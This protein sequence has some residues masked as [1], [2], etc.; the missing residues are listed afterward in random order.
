[1]KTFVS[2]FAQKREYVVTIGVF[3]GIHKGHQYLLEKLTESSRACDA[4]SLLI[5]FWPHPE[6]VL[7]KKAFG[8]CITTLSQKEQLLRR[9]APDY[10]FVLPTNKRL[11]TL[12]GEDFLKRILRVVRIKKIVVGDDFRFGYMAKNTVRDLR[13]FSEKFG[14]LLKVVKRKKVGTQIVS[15]T[16]I[17]N[18][19]AEGKVSRVCRFLGRNFCLEGEVVKGKGIGAK[20][21]YP[22]INVAAAGIILPARGVY[23]VKVLL[24]NSTYSGACNIGVAPTVSKNQKTSVEAHLLCVNRKVRSGEKVQIVFLKRMRDEKKFSS[25]EGLKNAIKE[26]VSFVTSK[27]GA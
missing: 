12:D 18:L 1:M 15:S 2:G 21:G 24:G 3:D 22:T 23:A 7:N 26:D 17:R 4:S 14:F 10:F 19:I 11:L 25:I 9:S 13:D 20:I 27:Y 16:F 5:T 6:Y 8:G